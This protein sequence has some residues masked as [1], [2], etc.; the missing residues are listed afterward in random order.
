MA[1]LGTTRADEAADFGRW[2]V[3]FAVINARR[4]LSG[5]FGI[6]LLWICI[7]SLMPSLGQW[8]IMMMAR[9]LL[10]TLSSGLLVLS[11]KGEG[12]FLLCVIMQCCLDLRPFGLLSGSIFLLLLL[13]L[14]MM[15][16]GHALLAS[17]SS[18]WLSWAPRIGRLIGADL[19]FG[20]ASYVVMLILC[21]LWAGER[22]VL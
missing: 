3:D 21:K 9:V 8:S 11:P 2:R 13:L 17:W 15:E 14:R 16:L 1:G 19:G 20:G 18:G 4:N 5:V 7:A 22:L 6:L 12:W 10:L